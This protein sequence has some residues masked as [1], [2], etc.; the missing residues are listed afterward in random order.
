MATI[1]EDHLKSLA[2]FDHALDRGPD[3]KKMAVGGAVVGIVFGFFLGR[4]SGRSKISAVVKHG[5]LGAGAGA[6]AAFG[7]FKIGEVVSDH[8]HAVVATAATKGDFHTGWSA[9]DFAA[10]IGREAAHHPDEGFGHG[11]DHGGHG[12]HGFGGHH[13]RW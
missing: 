8:S 12:G 10:H 5:A 6:V 2:A 3:Y 7:L 13:G 1:T 11:L 4:K 9:Q